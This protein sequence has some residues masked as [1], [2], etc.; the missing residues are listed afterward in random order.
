MYQFYFILEWHSTYFGRS[1]RPFRPSS[2]V[3]DCTYSNKHLS[4]RY[5]CLLA[6]GYRLASSWF[7][8]R[9]NITMHGPMN[10]KLAEVLSQNYTVQSDFRLPPVTQRVAVI[11]YRRFGTNYRSRQG[12]RTQEGSMVLDSWPLNM[13]PICCP[14]TSARNYYYSLRNSQEEGSC[15][16]NSVYSIFTQHP[17]HYYSHE[18]PLIMKFPNQI[19]V[20]DFR[21]PMVVPWLRRFVAGL[22]HRRPG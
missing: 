3:Q 1:F 18:W 22:W 4:N 9:N 12:S 14:E 20:C 5:C 17:L 8:Y 19:F 10:V 21:F 15:Q 13:E 11:P 2:G 7:Y 16:M 6:S